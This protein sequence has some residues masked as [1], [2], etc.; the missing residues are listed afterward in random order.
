MKHLRIL[1]IGIATLGLAACHGK[2][3]SSAGASAAVA[4]VNGHP[5]TRQFYDSYIKM[6]SGGR[7]PSELTPQQRAMVLDGLIRAEAVAQAAVKQG[8]DKQPHTETML[9]LTRL[10]VLEQALSNQ[11]LASAGPT[12][13]Q[14]Q[15]VYDQQLAKFPQVEYHARHILVKSQTEAEQIIHQLNAD[16]DRNFAQLAKKDS[17]DPGSAQN[18]GDLGWF[19]P[20]N[21]VPSFSAALAKLKVGQIT[22]TPVHTRFGWHVIQL[23]G[24]RPMHAPSF[25]QV[26]ARLKQ[27]VENKKFQTYTSSLVKKAKVETYLDPQTGSLSAKPTAGMPAIPAPTAPAAAPAGAPA[28]TGAPSATPAATPSGH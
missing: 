13:A 1:C 27:A 18:G 22:Q 12:D 9:K 10:N 14:L 2:S 24:T 19:P 28:P 23:L 3:T 21:M 6:V 15:S 8:L 5:I 20:N 11:Y 25:A 4:T 16:H 7:T 17:Q 26:K